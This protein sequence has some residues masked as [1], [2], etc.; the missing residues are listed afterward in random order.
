M[1]WDFPACRKTVSVDDGKGGRFAR[2]H[3]DAVEH[4]LAARL[5]GVEDQIAIPT[6]L[7]P[8]NMIRSAAAQRSSASTRASI[9]SG[10]G[11]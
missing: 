7:P 1:T 4:H 10:T 8:E 3:G 9:A 6:E 5:H 2:P 11:R